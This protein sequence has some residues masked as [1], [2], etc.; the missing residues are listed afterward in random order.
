MRDNVRCVICGAPSPGLPY[1]VHLMSN[2]F[3]NGQWGRVFPVSFDVCQEHH[4]VF[5]RI[6]GWARELIDEADEHG[7]R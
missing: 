7:W 2:G 4:Y 6:R 5:D 3:M 1:T